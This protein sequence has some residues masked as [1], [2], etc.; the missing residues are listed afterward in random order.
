MEPQIDNEALTHFIIES[1][2]IEGVSRKSNEEF[3]AY[4]K[5]LSL[6]QI[7][8]PA[9]LELADS[10]YLSGKKELGLLRDATGRN[11]QVGHYHPPPG[12][13]GIR[14]ELNNLLD[15]IRESPPEISPHE[16]HC[17]YETLHPLMDG[18]G[19]TGRALWLWMHLR[20]GTY[21]ER[22]FLVQFY[23]ETLANSSVIRES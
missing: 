9:I 10:L 7:D 19:R 8:I 21:I 6:H 12:G 5:L 22:G 1:N 13:P 11:V 20:Q 16:M 23:Y 15:N 2:Q 18:N 4:W 14:D 3:N 17:W